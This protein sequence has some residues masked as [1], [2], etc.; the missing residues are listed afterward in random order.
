MIEVQIIKILSFYLIGRSAINS[1][2]LDWVGYNPYIEKRRLRAKAWLITLYISSIMSYHGIYQ[3]WTFSPTNLT[4][5]LESEDQTS[6]NLTTNFLAAM[7]IDIIAGIID[8]RSEID[9]LS[10]WVHHFVYSCILITFLKYNWSNS[11]VA[12]A[13]AEIPT[14]LLSIG[15]VFPKI[16]QT[17]RM[18][19]LFF[20]PTRIILC[21]FIGWSFIFSGRGWIRQ[22]ITLPVFCVHIFWCLLL[23]KTK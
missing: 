11:F 18:I 8:Y 9:F 4:A 22:I 23:L 16:R 19:G 14:F 5:W 10:G 21:G 3:V 15:N 1:G 2:L 17:N 13:L 20:F 7:L 6:R 12:C